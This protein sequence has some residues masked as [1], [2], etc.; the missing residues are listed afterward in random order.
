[1]DSAGDVF[2]AGWFAGTVD[3]DPSAGVSDLTAASNGSAFV[4]KLTQ[5]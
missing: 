5:S 1:V 4:W 2:V 3:F